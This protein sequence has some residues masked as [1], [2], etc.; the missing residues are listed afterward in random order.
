MGAADHRPAGHYPGRRAV[1]PAHYQT[2]AADIFHAGG[3]V[4][5]GSGTI[6]LPCGAG[7]TMVGWDHAEAAVQHLILTPSTVAV[8]QWID[9]ILDK[10]TVSRTRSAST[11]AR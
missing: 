11:P 9:E 2:E 5:G 8:R 3:S 4:R 1:R 6:V 10:T 7:K